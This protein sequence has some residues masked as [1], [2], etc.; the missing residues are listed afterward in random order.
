MSIQGGCATA[1]REIFSGIGSRVGN[2]TY[3]YL[4]AAVRTREI[5]FRPGK[6]VGG[7]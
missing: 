4:I 7:K 3:R 6:G 2:E 1:Y 5:A